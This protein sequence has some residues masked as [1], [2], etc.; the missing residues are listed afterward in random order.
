MQLEPNATLVFYSHAAD[1]VPTSSEAE[2]D[3]D[4]AQPPMQMRFAGPPPPSPA[5]ASEE[6]RPADVWPMPPS[7]SATPFYDATIPLD[8]GWNE[9][10]IPSSDA[11]LNF[12]PVDAASHA[13][14]LSVGTGPPD[15][16]VIP[17]FRAVPVPT[18]FAIS[19]TVVADSDTDVGVPAIAVVYVPDVLPELHHLR[20]EVP[21]SIS[22][23]ISNV[24]K[25]RSGDE[26][27]YFSDLTAVTPQPIPAI[28]TFVAQPRWFTQRP[29]VFFDC[30]RVDQSLFACVVW[31]TLSRESL[32]LAA[33]L[34]PSEQFD[35][36]VHG[37]L[38]PLQYGQRISLTTGML[39]TLVPLGCGAPATASLEDR[40]HSSDG[41][42]DEN[43]L[44]GPST[45]P[46]QHF[47]VLTDGPAC[48]YTVASGRRGHFCADLA[49]QLGAEQFRITFK[50]STPRIL[51]GFFRGFHTSSL[52]VVTDQVCRLPVPPARRLDRRIILILDC[53]YILQA[54]VWQLLDGPEVGVQTLV[55][56]FQDECPPGHIVSITGAPVQSRPHGPVFLL[57]DGQVLTV[58]YIEDMMPS[59]ASSEAPDTDDPDEDGP[60]NRKPRHNG[61][62]RWRTRQTGQDTAR[63]RSRSPRH[64]GNASTE[65]APTVSNVLALS[66]RRTDMWRAVFPRDALLQSIR[67]LTSV[68]RCLSGPFS[69]TTPTH[70]MHSL[71]VNAVN[72]FIKHGIWLGSCA[73]VDPRAFGQTSDEDGNQP[74]RSCHELASTAAP[75]SL[76]AEHATHGDLT[77]AAFALLAPEYTAEEIQL[78]L[79]FPIPVADLLQALSDA[80]TPARRELLPTLVPVSPQ[81]DARWGT[82][83]ALPQW[84]RQRLVVCFDLYALD[85][86]I[87]AVQVPVVT[88][89][90]WLLHLAGLPPQTDVDIFCPCIDGPVSDGVDICLQVGDC[91]FRLSHLSF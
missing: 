33:G 40:L 39:I 20:L 1:D 42:G 43:D 6:E 46:G 48:R 32:L 87:F 51:T 28:I 45:I 3:A 67:L 15:E 55:N 35:I 31:P 30:R 58:A 37:L 84:A 69:Q 22:Q 74:S 26:G 34:R 63:H 12:R 73:C 90:F 16:P 47:W 13:A 77:R 38:Q 10:V 82:L 71:L 8:H 5:A 64:A 44:A 76:H 85:S 83:L 36:Y 81:P 21:C 23:A 68:L 86:R 50:A 7:E 11:D 88:D 19:D 52:L 24:Q 57:K 78:A 9:G 53:R 89:R 4:L 54:F 66:H 14:M 2:S 29:V 91:Y 17:T 49:S 62:N 70:S 59:E 61:R 41:W 79:E 27:M 80:R 65:F 25:L 72:G 75:E 18:G 56:Q 60:P